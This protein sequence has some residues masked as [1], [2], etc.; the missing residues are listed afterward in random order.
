MKKR[1]FFGHAWRSYSK[2]DNVQSLHQGQ[3]NG[4]KRSFF[5]F[6]CMM[7]LLEDRQCQVPSLRASKWETN[8]V[9]LFSRILVLASARAG[10]KID[11]LR[12]HLL[13][14]QGNAMVAT[15]RF[16]LWWS[17]IRTERKIWFV[18]TSMV[19]SLKE[20]MSSPFTKVK[21]REKKSCF[22]IKRMFYSMADMSSSFTKGK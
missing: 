3:V 10:T 15:I 14:V 20:T 9:L 12:F 19:V 8:L 7:V 17:G 6:P 5:A 13:Q 21:Y 11:V 1:L 16:S 22:C 18:F 2:I 4:K